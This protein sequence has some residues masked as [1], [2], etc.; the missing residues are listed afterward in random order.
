MVAEGSSLPARAPRVPNPLRHPI[1]RAFL[2]APSG[3]IGLVIISVL[4]IAIV[5]APFFLQDAANELH[6]TEQNQGPSWSHPLG[7]DQIGRDTLARTLLAGGLSLKIA[8]GAA[9][10]SFMIGM[11]LGVASAVVGRRTRPFIQRF[12]DTMIAF[13]ALILVIFISIITGT[14]VFGII[15]GVGIGGSFGFARLTS[16]LALSIGGRDFISAARVLGVRRLRLMYRHVLPNLAEPLIVSLSFILVFGLLTSAGLSF[17]GLGVK[18]PD[19]DW[20]KM[21]T[22]G[23]RVIYA[24]PEQA[25]APAAALAIAALSFGFFGEALARSTNPRLWTAS[26]A[27]QRSMELAVAVDPRSEEVLDAHPSA[28]PWRTRNGHG[29][30]GDVAALEVQDLVVSFPREG[31]SVEVVKGVSFTIPRGGVLGIVGESG[32]GKTMTAL[33]VARLTPYPGRVSGS[34]RLGGKDLTRLSQRELNK[35]LGNDLTFVF[36]DPM[37]SLNPALTIGRHLAERAEVHRKLGRKAARELAAARL[38]DVHIPAPEVQ[39]RRYPHEFSGGMR[40]RAMI[41]M[42]LMNDPMLLICDEPTTALDVTIQAQIMDLLREVNERHSTA[43]ILIS[44]NLALVAQN[45]DRVIVMYAGRIVEDL[46][47]DELLHDAKHPYTRALLGALPVLEHPR[48]QPLAYIPGEAP[49]MA[50]P[51]SGCPFHPRCPL[52]IDLCRSERPPLRVRDGGRRVACHVANDDL[53]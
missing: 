9:A 25:L 42:A 27:E 26:R 4:V 33:A 18:E 10:V 52:A 37:S 30:A 45:C 43:M 39:L 22:D 1:A 49:E 50:A 14:G 8:L 32:S 24:Y 51:P 13:P 15:L 28:S 17:L 36:Q 46:D 53:T 11:T 20:G 5:V 44:H 38:R 2:R 48:E 7:T 35:V 41:A 16:T 3:V 6:V 19:Y 12:I 21:L 47:V 31:G 34:A 29:S 23:V 40:Q